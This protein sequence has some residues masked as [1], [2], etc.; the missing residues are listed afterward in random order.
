VVFGNG[1]K[2]LHN[3]GIELCAGTTANLFV[4]VRHRKRIAIRAVA[5]HNI[6]SIGDGDDACPER[7]LFAAQATWIARTIE[8]LMVGEDDIGGVAQKRNAPLAC[9]SQS[10]SECT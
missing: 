3:F 6:E 1:K 4:R 2:H 5:Q 8:E 9:Y 7:N 10:R